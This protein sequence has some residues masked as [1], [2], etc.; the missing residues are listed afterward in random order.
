VRQ[1][2]MPVDAAALVMSHSSHR[3][4]LTMA[5]LQPAP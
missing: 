4:T 5:S 2:D 1:A 3:W